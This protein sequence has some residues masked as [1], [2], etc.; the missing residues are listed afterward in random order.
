M[1]PRWLPLYL[2]GIIALTLFPF[3]APECNSGGWVLRMGLPDIVANLLAFLP[4]GLALHRLPL[5]RALGLAIALS[6][7]IEL[8]QAYLPRLQ[9]VMDLVS[10]ALGA[11]LGHRLGVA[12]TTRWQGPL[13]RPVTRRI[14]LLTATAV[15]LIGA[16]AEAVVAPANDFSNW[17]DLPLIIGNSVQGDRPWMGAI[18]EVAIF[19]R[20]LDAA[21]TPRSA[22]NSETPALWAEGGPILWLRFSGD[23]PSGRV[24]G[25]AGPVRYLPEVGRST[26]ITQ[27]GLRLLASGIA[28]DDWVSDHVVKQLKRSGRLT[29]DV[30]LRAAVAHQYGPAQIVSLGNGRGGRNLI[31][32]QRGSGLTARIRTPANGGNSSKPEVQTQWGAI[33]PEPQHVRFT[34]DGSWATIRIDGNCE[35][36]RHMAL[37]SALPMMGAFLGLT[38]VLC[39]ALPALALASFS[40]SPRRRLLLAGAG[41]CGAWSLLWASGIWNSLGD[42]TLIAFLIGAFALLSTLPLLL[43][44]R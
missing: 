12:W 32:G 9:D 41:G 19:D 26:A 35:A 8:C 42:Y 44:P 29:L 36:S 23:D 33:R 1:L 7:T 5:L 27:A 14:L 31:L 11:F 2:T 4:I 21:D 30:H 22:G 3:L 17:A 43:R 40:R 10:N 20:A 38:L 34:F 13:L 18:S 28:L 24:D 37:T 39:T 16:L 6:L 15:L 25:P